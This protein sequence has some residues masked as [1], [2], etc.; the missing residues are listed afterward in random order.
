M[1]LGVRSSR[2]GEGREARAARRQGHQWAAALGR[3][4][5]E[6]LSEK[7]RQERSSRATHL[8]GVTAGGPRR[9]VG[10][11][12]RPP[13]G[14]PPRAAEH[15]RQLTGS[16]LCRTHSA[17]APGPT[18]PVGGGGR[19]LPQCLPDVVTRSTALMRDSQH[20]SGSGLGA[21]PSNARVGALPHLPSV[22]VFGGGGLW[23][24]IRFK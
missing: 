9:R 7:W 20:G 24:V 13:R 16:G 6:S 22:V 8:C 23:E 21:A 10:C 1:P 11:V 5:A 18:V 14:S 2:A 19:G 3:G 4:P 17:R 12:S 15:Q